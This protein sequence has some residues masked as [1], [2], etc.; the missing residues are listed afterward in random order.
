MIWSCR[1]EL[2]LLF[3][4]RTQA[5]PSGRPESVTVSTSIPRS[6]RYVETKGN[7]S[8]SSRMNT[9]SARERL[10]TGSLLSHALCCRF[11][12]WLFR[13]EDPKP[14]VTNSLVFIDENFGMIASTVIW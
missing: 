11:H 13:V 5:V 9:V 12:H 1:S 3:R 7:F 4:I 14:K 10:H 2:K 8:A 6:R